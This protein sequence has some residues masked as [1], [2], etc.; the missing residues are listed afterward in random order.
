ML[1]H[2]EPHSQAFGTAGEPVTAHPQPLGR[3]RADRELGA[4]LCGGC[5]AR[6]MQKGMWE[7]RVRVGMEGLD[8][9]F[10][11]C[12]QSLKGVE[13]LARNAVWRPREF[14]RGQMQVTGKKV[15]PS[16]DKRRMAF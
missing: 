4:N 14:A 10:Q 16:F 1:T 6:D 13:P 8:V 5:G 11:E 2:M 3:L 12:H 15:T 9:G 7:G